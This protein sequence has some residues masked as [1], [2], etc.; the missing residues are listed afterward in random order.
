MLDGQTIIVVPVVVAVVVVLVWLIVRWL[1]S[2]RRAMLAASKMVLDNEH[3][4]DAERMLVLLEGLNRRML[5]VT[6]MSTLFL[7]LTI[8]GLVL[9][10]VLAATGNLDIGNVI[11]SLFTV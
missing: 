5:P 8:L 7:V 3:M 11:E 2:S 1:T 10:V 6:I 4:T 9:I